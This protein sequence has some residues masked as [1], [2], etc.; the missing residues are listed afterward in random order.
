MGGVDRDNEEVDQV[1]VEVL[2]GLLDNPHINVCKAWRGIILRDVETAEELFERQVDGE[3][4]RVGSYKREVHPEPV[5]SGLVPTL[6]EDLVY[7]VAGGT[8]QEYAR[9]IP[10]VEAVTI[11]IICKV[12]P[13]E[14][15]LVAVDDYQFAVIAVV[16]PQE[17]PAL[18]GIEGE[19]LAP[20]G[21]KRGK[22]FAFGLTAE[23]IVGDAD[24]YAALCR[25]DQVFEY[26]AA[27]II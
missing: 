3:F 8:A 10:A 18:E 6:R 5:A 26:L 7:L 12:Y 2:R 14:E 13:G 19:Y 23:V 17:G 27:D 4:H 22:I 11:I 20:G 25:R 21:N 15:G 1:A 24:T 16:H 9:V